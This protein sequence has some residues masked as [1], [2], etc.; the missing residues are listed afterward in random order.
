MA[1]AFALLLLLAC[2]SEAVFGR[3]LNQDVLRNF[4]A[5]GIRCTA[6]L[7]GGWQWVVQAAA[8][9][10]WMGGAGWACTAQMQGT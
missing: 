4:S 8:G 5:D 2:A 9:G 1:L 3:Q 6:A 10:T 7:A